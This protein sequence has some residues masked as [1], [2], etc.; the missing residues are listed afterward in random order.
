MPAVLT[1]SD[2]W[3]ADKKAE[4]I[5]GTSS[6]LHPGVDY[7]INNS[8][9]HY[10]GGHIEGTEVASH[11]DFEN[12]WSSPPKLRNSFKKRGWRDV[13]A[14]QTSQP[15]H[16]VHQHIILKA[17]RETQAHILIHPTVGTTKA[18]DLDYYARVHC[19][20]AIEKYFPN[21][22]AMM[23]LLP[24]AMRMLALKKRYGMPLLIKILVVHIFLSGQITLRLLQ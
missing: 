18:G 12:L 10:I 14:F 23:S 2:I 9:S 7:L 5:Y 13:L 21:N 1:V 8:H 4:A 6:E 22:L 16:K 24:M 15:M 17:A 19:Y 11:F 20:Q 3:E